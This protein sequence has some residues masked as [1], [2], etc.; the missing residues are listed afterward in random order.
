M[1][2]L[3]RTGNVA[4]GAR[5]RIPRLKV[6]DA[7]RLHHSNERGFGRLRRTPARI[8]SRAG[9][10]RSLQI[11][12]P[13]SFHT[14]EDDEPHQ[15]Y[16]Y[17]AAVLFTSLA[18]D[19]CSDLYSTIC[20]PPTSRAVKRCYLKRAA[21]NRSAGALRAPLDPNSGRSKSGIKPFS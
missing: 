16:P 11:R 3:R 19:P 20:I 5:T 13:D 9:V 8:G 2:R 1:T 14:R 21:S 10:S 4:T 7:H 17:M 6:A 15:M 12:L 18:V